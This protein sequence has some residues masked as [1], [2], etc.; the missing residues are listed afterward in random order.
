MV[1]CVHYDFFGRAFD[2][3]QLNSVFDR[4]LT[5]VHMADKRFKYFLEGRKFKIVTDQRSLTHAIFCRNQIL[6]Y[7]VGKKIAPLDKVP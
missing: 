1:T 6:K 7:R 5:A 2:N 4:E 3:A